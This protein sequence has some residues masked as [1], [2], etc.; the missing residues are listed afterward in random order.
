MCSSDL[1]AYVEKFAAETRAGLDALR[2]RLTSERAAK[3]TPFDENAR[4]FATLAALTQR[5]TDTDAA[6]DALA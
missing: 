2:E 6:L 3:Q 1:S 5:T 4:I